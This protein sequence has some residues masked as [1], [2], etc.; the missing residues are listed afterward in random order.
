MTGERI[1]VVGDLINDVVVVPRGGLRV[2]TDT[3]ASIRQ[4]PGGSGA[5][6]AAWL[7]SLGAPVD[8]V[9]AV[10]SGDAEW[11]RA[12]FADRGVRA[13]LQVEVGVPTGTV[14]ILVDGERRTMLTERGANALLDSRA[15]TYALLAEAA[16]VHLS[17]Y[18][19][20]DG[21]GVTGARDVV[22]RATAAGVPVA[23]NPG[24]AGFIA[25]FGLDAF[26]AATCGVSLIF[27][28][29][30]EGELLTGHRSPERIAAALLTHYETVVLTL[31]GDGVYAV[32]RGG[33]AVHTPAPRVRLVDP[34]GA[35]DAFA[36][37][38]LQRWMRSRDLAAASAAGVM[39]AARAIVAIGGRPAI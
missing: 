25:D 4:R 26:R 31:G 12:Q 27:P 17:A 7:G 14:V 19:F 20:L 9:G 10:G 37:G 3:A 38:F 23:L 35:G 33:Q 30:A 24:S 32:T 36:A 39:V 29:L 5:N 15:L 1:V 18:S 22:D 11:H 8:Y 21:F 16:Y 13:H 28:N 34:T 6:T 2:D